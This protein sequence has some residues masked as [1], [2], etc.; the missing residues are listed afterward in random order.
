MGEGYVRRAGRLLAAGGLLAATLAATPAMAQSGS[1]NSGALARKLVDACVYDQYPVQGS[2]D[3]VLKR[4]Q[5]AARK[6]G[7]SINADQVA[8]LQLG[9]PLTGSVRDEVYKGIAACR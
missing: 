4:C 6:A 2:S 8:S 5:C 3:G 9:A 7:P 1:T